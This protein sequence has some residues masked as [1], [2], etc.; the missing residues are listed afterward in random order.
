MIACSGRPIAVNWLASQC[1]YVLR[2][3]IAQPQELPERFGVVLAHEDGRLEVARPA[4]H[5]PM[6]LP[7]ATWMALARAN[8]ERP[9]DEDV[10]PLLAPVEPPPAAA[11]AGA[12]PFGAGGSAATPDSAA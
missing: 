7:F 4:A 2:E 11:P 5:R 6:R 10:Q 1:W 12:Q 8:A 3:G 9:L